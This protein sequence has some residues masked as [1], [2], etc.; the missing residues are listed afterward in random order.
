M[1]GLPHRNERIALHGRSVTAAG[2]GHAEAGD[3]TKIV[4][5]V[6]EIRRHDGRWR[7]GAP[8][9]RAKQA[10]PAAVDLEADAKATR[11]GVLMDVRIRI[12]RR[13]L[14]GCGQW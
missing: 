1:A 12:R 13:G 3:F 9:C 6:R 11:D 8:S 5:G 4:E 2:C 7:P 10:S 14:R